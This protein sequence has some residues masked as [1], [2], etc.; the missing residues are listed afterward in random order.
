MKNTIILMLASLFVS[1]QVFAQ[2]KALENPAAAHAQATKVTSLLVEHKFTEAFDML[3]DYWPLEGYQ[4]DGLRQTTAKQIP[5][6][7][8]SFGKLLGSEFVRSETLGTF[9]HV[10]FF[11]LKYEKNAL[12]LYFT[13]YNG[14][15][16]W[17]INSVQWDDRWDYLFLQPLKNK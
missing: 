8:E 15:N 1:A 2:T 7:E 9:G 16:G 17:L 11:V 3:K 12:R 5:L 10:E 4:I 14:G 13:Y 6:L